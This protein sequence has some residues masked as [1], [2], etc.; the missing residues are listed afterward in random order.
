VPYIFHCPFT[1]PDF[2]E[3]HLNHM[4]YIYLELSW[5]NLSKY[6][7]P[8]NFHNV[9][10]VL[11]HWKQWHVF[12]SLKPSKLILCFQFPIFWNSTWITWYIYHWYC[13]DKIYQN[14][15]VSQI[16]IILQHFYTI[17][18]TD[19]FSESLSPS[20]IGENW[21][22]FCNVLFSGILLEYHDLYIIGIVFMKSIKIHKSHQLPSY[23]NI[24]WP[25]KSLICFSQPKTFYSS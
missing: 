24:Y 4:I 9:V 8:I 16:S 10:T 13:C 18:C 14:I 2:L 20:N 19:M 5:S 3:F 22:F 21:C 6:S 1:I 15:Q 11:H 25:P 7:S 12:P 17:V 23:C